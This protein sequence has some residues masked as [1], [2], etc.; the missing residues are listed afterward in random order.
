MSYLPPDQI[1]AIAHETS[2]NWIISEL[3]FDISHRKIIKFKSAT[4]LEKDLSSTL[5]SSLRYY[6]SRKGK[7]KRFV[8]NFTNLF[9]PSP[10]NES[11]TQKEQ[12]ALYNSEVFFNNR[13]SMSF[14]SIRGL[15]P[16]DIDTNMLKG[17][18]KEPI[19]NSDVSPMMI[20]DQSNK[21][22][23]IKHFK[24]LN[25]DSNDNSKKFLIGN[26]EVVL[27]YDSSKGRSNVLVYRHPEN[28]SFLFLCIISLPQ[29]HVECC[30]KDFLK[31]YCNI[32]LFKND[33]N[34]FERRQDDIQDYV[35]FNDNENKCIYITKEL[36]EDISLS[37][38]EESFSF[39][40]SFE[41]RRRYLRKSILLIVPT[42]SVFDKKVYNDIIE[43]L[44]NYYDCYD[45]EYKINGLNKQLN[46]YFQSLDSTKREK[47]REMRKRYY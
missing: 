44:S 37:N 16:I 27:P 31:D 5:E 29:H 23:P 15:K 40:G 34:N 3:P 22:H 4:D 24:V 39:N 1:I 47:Q 45:N 42:D 6:R 43:I 14:P 11:E 28:R 33:G 25:N 7:W 12:A 13:M 20:V 10:I 35:I 19:S 8:S 9:K 41:Y 2:G 18:F 32:T 17:F 26:T 21:Q 38:Y 30:N 46:E 36:Y